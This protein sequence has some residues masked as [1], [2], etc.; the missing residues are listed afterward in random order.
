MT[1]TMTSRKPTDCIFCKII[2]REI[3]SEIVYEDDI[4]FCFLDAHP[5]NGGHTLVIPKQHH[6]DIYALPNDTAGHLFQTA[7]R[8]ARAI[9]KAVAADG[10][11]IGMNNEV[12]AGQA[13]FHAHIHVIPRYADDGYAMWQPTNAST[14]T[15][16]VIAEDIKKAL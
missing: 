4:A 8:L 2:A 15:H 3:P 9:K 13:V 16:A 12:A 10:I 14:K 5:L 11:N 7:T 6:Q 1:D